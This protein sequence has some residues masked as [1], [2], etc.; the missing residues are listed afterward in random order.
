MQGYVLCFLSVAVVVSGCSSD[1][2]GPPLEPIDGIRAVPVASGLQAPVHLTAPTGDERLF[3]VEQAG[4]I[5]IIRNGTLLPT[6]FLDITDRVSFGGEQGLFSVAFDPD[7][8]STG[9]FWVDYTDDA[10]DTR[11]ERYTVSSDPDVADPASALL[12]L[13]VD[14]PFSNHNGGQLAFGPDGMLYI[15]MGDGGSG[16]DPLGHGQNPSTLLGALL[17]IDVKSA[18]P[19]GIP[20]DNPYIGSTSARPEVWAIGLRNPWRFSFDPATDRLYIADVG[21]GDWEEINAVPD[22]AAPLNYGWNIMEGPEC[23][24]AASCSQTGLTTPIHS[25]PHPDGCS[26]TGGFVYRGERLGGLQ[27]HYFYSDYCGGW[28]RSLRLAGGAATDHR[29]WAVGDIGQVLSFGVDAD[30]ELYVL[31]GNGSVYRLDPSD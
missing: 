1:G 11:I 15:G 8:A 23:F 27:G 9:H 5:R 17:R 13:A 3:V 24:N 12:V 2:T 21:Q 19:Y 18:V 22:D 29:E 26:V 28:L 10:G 16:G 7:F 6:P 20:A 4:R 30:G 25:Y 31:S 14:Q